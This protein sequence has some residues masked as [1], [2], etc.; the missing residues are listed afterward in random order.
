[1]EKMMNKPEDY[2]DKQ[3]IPYVK[4]TGRSY[5]YKT[6]NIL[7]ELIGR[8]WDEISLGYV[9]AFKPSCIRVIPHNGMMTLD[10]MSRRVTVEL[11]EQ[12]R[13]KRINQEVEV[14]LPEN[15]QNGE[16]LDIAMEHGIDSPQAQWYNDDS[17]KGFVHDGINGRYYKKCD[18]G[19]VEFPEVKKD[20]AL[21]RY[22][23]IFDELNDQIARV[24]HIPRRYL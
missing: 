5:G 22:Q 16:H 12:K 11:N 17:I 15:I 8:Q 13:I 14:M 21:E 2:I 20:V 4:D 18:E 24:F 1:M 9:H 3:G 7:P 10:A 19:L 6:I 23:K